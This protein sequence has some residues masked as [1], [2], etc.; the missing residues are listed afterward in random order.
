MITAS[1]VATDDATGTAASIRASGV[2]LGIGI[3]SG[4]ASPNMASPPVMVTGAGSTV[5]PVTKRSDKCNF[6]I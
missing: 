4:K 1:V 3:G 6:Y 5:Y 2:G